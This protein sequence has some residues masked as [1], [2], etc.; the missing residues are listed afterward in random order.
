MYKLN[1]N[2]E[3]IN[4]GDNYLLYPWSEN[5]YNGKCFNIFVNTCEINGLW[6]NKYI[7][8]N[9]WAKRNP[10]PDVRNTGT[11]GNNA[12]LKLLLD[13]EPVEIGGGGVKNRNLN[14]ENFI[15]IDKDTEFIL[16]TLF[17][18]RIINKLYQENLIKTIYK[19][20][21]IR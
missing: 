13:R 8:M 2:N 14:D 19:I 20:L 9:P 18:H 6:I 11:R 12:V 10:K 21:Q 1:Y 7:Y 3:T 16:K 17:E 5:L 4:C 15:L